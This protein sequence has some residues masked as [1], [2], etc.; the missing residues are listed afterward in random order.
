M[1]KNKVLA[2]TSVLISTLF[3]AGAQLFL[4]FSYS[5]DSVTFL[6]FMHLNYA[7]FIGLACYGL[8]A[9]LFFISMKYEEVSTIFPIYALGYIWVSIFA[10]AYLGDQI[11]LT[12]G[13]GILSS[14][15]GVIIIAER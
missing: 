14:I 5:F 8:G 6:G 9:A 7:F 12:K 2:L 3:T 4:S 13:L 15:L 1:K 10:V 11:N